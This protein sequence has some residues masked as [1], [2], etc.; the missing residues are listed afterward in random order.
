MPGAMNVVGT[1]VPASH[2]AALF[3]DG[4]AADAL[5]GAFGGMPA[6]ELASFRADM[7]FDLHIGGFA[8][9]TE[10]MIAYALL[11][12]AVF[13]A[14]AVIRMKRRGSAAVTYASEQG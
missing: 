7:G 4:M 12:T 3:R 6:E 13:F 9:S 2:M 8:F 10:T 14:V 11:V 5:N 1:L